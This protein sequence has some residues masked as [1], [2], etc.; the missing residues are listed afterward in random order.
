MQPID[1]VIFIVIILVLI[2]ITVFLHR[3]EAKSK[4]K[5]KIAAYN[6]LEEKNPDPQK[7]KNTIRMLSLYG[8]RF[9]R[10]QEF[11]QLIR[12]LTDLLHETDKS[13]ARSDKKVKK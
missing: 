2:G 11:D 7:I 4:N 12:M 10:D 9:R 5:H 1:I 8:G 13:S 3:S 6:L